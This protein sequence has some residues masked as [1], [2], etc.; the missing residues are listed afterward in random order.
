[1]DWKDFFRPSWKKVLVFIILY[2][3]LMP[4][5]I[6]IWNVLDCRPSSGGTG[7]SCNNILEAPI[8]YPLEYMITITFGIFF[9]KNTMI[10]L[11]L[12]MPVI[13]YLLACALVHLLDKKAE[14]KGK[15]E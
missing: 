13:S 8:K 10:L 1:M 2:I 6:C 7:C 15:K 9:Y 4:F 14:K 12:V 5:A 3:V 11:Y